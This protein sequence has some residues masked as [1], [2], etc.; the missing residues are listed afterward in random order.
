VMAKEK[1]LLLYEIRDFQGIVSAARPPVA[2]VVVPKTRPA[3]LGPGAPPAA[4]KPIALSNSAK[5]RL[6]SDSKAHEMLTDD[7]VGLASALKNNTLAMES[8]VRERGELVAGAEFALD[9]SVAGTKE[10]A[11][12]ATAAHRRGRLNFCFTCLIMLI[13][14]T[15]FAAMYIF[16]RITSFTGYK[17]SKAMKSAYLPPGGPVPHTEL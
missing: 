9:R 7:L 17:S 1:S 15:G 5:A 16:I 4:I 11:A 13:I 10:A 8:K 14:G 2:P 12:R 3:Y 6:A